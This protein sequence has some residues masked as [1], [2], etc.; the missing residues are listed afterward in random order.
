MEL[1]KCFYVFTSKKCNYVFNIFLI[2]INS[3]GVMLLCF[4]E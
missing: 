2:V 1:T 4:I 3:G